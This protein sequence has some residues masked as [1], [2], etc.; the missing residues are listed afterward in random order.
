MR[1]TN[2]TVLFIHNNMKYI[3]AFIVF[4]ICFTAT[5]Y[6][7]HSA[8]AHQP[9]T[10]L[11]IGDKVPDLLIANFLG[12]SHSAMKLSELYKNGG[13][14]INF[15]ATWCAPCLTELPVLNELAE[16]YHS[17]LG[18]LS[19]EYEER[20][21]VSKFLKEHPNITVSNFCLLAGDTLLVEY[22]KHRSLPYN[23]WI[24]S[25]GIIK[26]ITH[27]DEINDKNINNFVHGKA[28]KSSDA[29]DK[30]NFSFTEP[31]HYKDSAFLYRSILTKHTPGIPSGFNF[32]SNTV[33]SS[34][35]LINRIYIFNLSI[36]Q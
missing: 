21:T 7:Q 10:Q 15:W 5:S 1:V 4:L 27:G 17:K 33:S 22:L 18:V 28:I 12:R 34:K 11:K 2:N 16:K 35:W 6:A 29:Q 30:T 3:I 25:L 23:V 13:L 31:F 20:E 26:H 24:D 19:V 9:Q 14:I 8:K 32:L 36:S